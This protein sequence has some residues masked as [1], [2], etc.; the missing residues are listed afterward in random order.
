MPIKICKLRMA[1]PFGVAPEIPAIKIHWGRSAF[2]TLVSAGWVGFCASYQMDD[3]NTDYFSLEITHQGY[4][5]I[6][7]AQLETGVRTITI[8]A[9]LLK[10]APRWAVRVPAADFAVRELPTTEISTLVRRHTTQ[11]SARRW[12]RYRR[13][14]TIKPISFCSAGL[15]LEVGREGCR[16]WQC[17][18]LGSRPREIA[19][20]VFDDTLCETR[21]IP[22]PNFGASFEAAISY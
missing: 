5:V 19:T 20:S 21:A 2:E 12:P 10:C 14:A 22:Y 17:C 4:F 6:H 3:W 13:G 1:A 18:T 9:R 15:R 16:S 11:P 7:A 8:S